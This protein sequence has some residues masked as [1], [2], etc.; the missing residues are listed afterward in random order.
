MVQKKSLILLGT[1]CLASSVNKKENNR[2]YRGEKNNRMLYTQKFCSS[3]GCSKSVLPLNTDFHIHFLFVSSLM[4]PETFISCVTWKDAARKMTLPCLTSTA[5]CSTCTSG[6]EPT[7]L[8]LRSSSLG[9]PSISSQNRQ[10]QSELLLAQY[11]LLKHRGC[12]KLINKILPIKS[13]S[14]FIMN[15][16]C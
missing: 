1:K 4:C 11:F 13:T 12:R 15:S 3:N 10:P 16:Y 6:P 9:Q 2:K 5:A 8:R 14:F 7:A